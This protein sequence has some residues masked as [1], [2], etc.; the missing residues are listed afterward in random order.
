MASV[1]DTLE[2]TLRSRVGLR[3]ALLFVGCAI[4]P[5]LGLGILTAHRTYS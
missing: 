3:M 4:V 1:R 5:L 2:R